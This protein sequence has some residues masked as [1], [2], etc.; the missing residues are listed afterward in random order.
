MTSPTTPQSCG[1]P[2]NQA[3]FTSGNGGSGGP[4]APVTITI[5]CAP[6]SLAKTT[7]T[8]IVDA[9]DQIRYRLTLTNPG[10]GTAHGVV[11]SDSLPP[12][13]GTWTIATGTTAT[14]CSIT[15]DALTCNQGSLSPGNVVVNLTSSTNTTDCPGVTNSASATS[16]NDGN[17]TAGPTPITINCAVLSLAKTTDTATVDAG[18]QIR[19][20]LTLTNP[21]PGTA[22][23]VVISDSL[24]RRRAPGPSPRAPRQLAAP[25]PVTH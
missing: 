12:T 18:D 11:I 1:Q 14:G 16:T 19:Y 6:L 24:P 25:S 9:G 17:P 22:H 7:D 10:P 5:N 3:S 15:G 8:A 21:G 23:G 13:S 20:R 2:S 4:T